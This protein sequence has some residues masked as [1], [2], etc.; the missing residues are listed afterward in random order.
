M[1]SDFLEGEPS[2]ENG[3]L[4]QAPVSPNNQWGAGSLNG[5]SNSRF[6]QRP[7]W[8]Q[9]GLHGCTPQQSTSPCPPHRTH[10]GPLA[11]E[12]R[13]GAGC[14]E[15]YFLLTPLCDVEAATSRK[16]SHVGQ[17]PSYRSTQSQIQNCRK[18]I[19]MDVC[20]IF[21][22]CNLLHTDCEFETP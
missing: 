5:V 19:D 3:S 8:K 2:Q 1:E 10:A 12:L 16:M 21:S 9:S 13:R 7:F 20:D 6:G 17:R 14:P 22:R 4:A 11:T 18:P 15:I